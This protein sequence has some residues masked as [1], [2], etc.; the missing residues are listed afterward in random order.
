MLCR[1]RRRKQAAIS[2]RRP[3]WKNSRGWGNDATVTRTG[4]VSH[5]RDDRRDACGVGEEEER[6][7]DEKDRLRQRE[8]E[9]E[10]ERERKIA[11]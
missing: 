4:F 8:S 3:V 11:S 6:V 5:V 1:E 9:R 7:G 2:A 10:E